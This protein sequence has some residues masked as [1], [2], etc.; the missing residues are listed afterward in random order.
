MHIDI[1]LEKIRACNTPGD[2]FKLACWA[3]GLDDKEIYSEVGIDAGYF[4]NI[5]KNAATLKAD[6]EALF[7]KVVG[8][9]IYPEWRAAQLGCSMVSVDRYEDLLAIEAAAKKLKIENELLLS[10]LGQRVRS[11]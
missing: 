6:K 5:K 7:C 2:A 8:N 1:P 4:T 10:V 9:R 3:S 11:A